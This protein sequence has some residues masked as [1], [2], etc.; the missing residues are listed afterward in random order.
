VSPYIY[1]RFKIAKSQ[2]VALN[3]FIKNKF[4]CEKVSKELDLTSVY[5]IIN[6]LKKN[7]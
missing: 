4:D 2:G 1:Q 6:K 7:K 5:E 3:R